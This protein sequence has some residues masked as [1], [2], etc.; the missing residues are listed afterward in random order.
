MR[1]S[2]LAVALMLTFAGTVHSGAA[3]AAS[4][5]EQ[6]ADIDV[7]VSV[8]PTAQSGRASAAV[9][10][11]AERGTVWSLLTSC[12]DAYRLVPGLVDCAVVETAPDRSWQLIRQ[13]IDYSWY[14]PR[15]TF[16]FRADYRYPDR[17]SIKR[18]SGDL[19]VLEGAWDLEQDG[20]FTIAR[21]SLAFAPGFW[22]PRWLVKA[23]LKREL[24]KA[25]RSL[26]SLAESRRDGT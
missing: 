17:V 3:A 10:I 1:S 21:C 23:A 4:D 24:P 2:I 6:H 19:R 26:R 14:V 22:V 9:R 13:V 25:L 16:V 11:R 20:D 8:D 12:K 15:L 5:A 7:K 18:V